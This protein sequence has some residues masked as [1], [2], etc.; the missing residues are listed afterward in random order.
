ML[1]VGTRVAGET[2]EG[3][4]R[5]DVAQIQRRRSVPARLFGMKIGKKSLFGNTGALLFIL[6]FESREIY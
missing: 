1:R 5:I 3:K 2:V 6:E 4:I